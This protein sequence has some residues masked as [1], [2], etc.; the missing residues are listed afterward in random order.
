M[1]G[2]KIGG[3]MTL[4]ETA[5][6]WVNQGFSVIPIGYYSKKP[7][8]KWQD[9]QDKLPTEFELL[10]WFPSELR[11]IG[12]ITGNGLVVIDFDVLDVFNYWFSLFPLKTYMV[13]TRRGVHV[14]LHTEQAAKNYHSDLLDIKAERGYVLIPPSVHPSGYQYQVFQD[15]PIMRIDKLEEVLPVE[16]TPEAEKVLAQPMT[17]EIEVDPWTLADSATSLE[18][19]IVKKI[20]ENV[21]LLSIIP[22]AERSSADG[23]WYV[24]LCPF[25]EDHTPSFWIDTQRGLCG[26]RKCNIKEMDVL[27]LF[28]RIHHISNQEAIRE[29]Q[30]LM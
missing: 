11:N 22:G 9:Y 3:F 16:F 14:Y 21:T 8:I 27:N 18:R 24:A 19:G 15:K 23:R 28:A 17:V 30:K 25:H 1:S 13:K 10:Q 6:S 2:C 20:R 4:F 5:L 26:C 7:I 29:L 12:L